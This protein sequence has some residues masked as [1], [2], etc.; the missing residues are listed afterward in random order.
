MGSVLLGCFD[1]DR[2]FVSKQS[3]ELEAM[4][5]ECESSR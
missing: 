3:R 1:S 2:T 5:E 4:R